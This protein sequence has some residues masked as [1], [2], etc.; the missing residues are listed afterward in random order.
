MSLNASLSIGAS[1]LWIN[2]KGIE[3]TGNN[4]ANV[5]TEGYSRQTLELSSTPALEFSG[6][7][8]GQGTT[9]SSISRETNSFV[10]KQLTGKI[11]D[12][13]EENGKSLPLE[14]IE[15][16][17]GIDDDSLSSSID[18]FFDAWQEL[19]TDSSASLQRQQVMQ[20]G[21]NL[22][23][24]FQSMVSDLNS[25]QEGINDDLSGTIATLN[26]QLQEI[27]DLN[28]RIVSAESTGVSANSLRDQRDLLLQGVSEVA[29][30]NYFE[31][32][33]GMV[34]VQLSSGLP[35]VTADTASLL[36]T[37]WNSGTL[38]L[39]LTSGASTKD[40]SGNDF[41]GEV[42][43]ILEVRDDYIP[44]LID[45]LDILAYNLATTVNS[46]HTGGVD[47][48]GNTGVDFYSFSSS[49]SDPWTGA[50]STLTMELTETSQVAAGT[51]AAPDNQLGDNENTLNMVALH[52]EALIDG[53][54]TFNDYYATI[55][56][57][58][59]LTVSQNTSALE[60][61]DDALTQMQNMRDSISG[62]SVDEEMIMLTQYQSG[63]EAA[64]R[65]LTAVDEML[66]TLM[67]I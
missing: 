36:A 23:L 49:G 58:V 35:L 24:E 51:I 26:Q 11:A 44:E 47:L 43:G 59:G 67:S 62:V 9:V 38:N 29:G 63:Y 41:G 31:E 33:N 16:I 19:S 32:S 56:S 17:V 34:S 66:E 28:V 55:A 53:T 46:V 10:S 52:S 22:A 27:A 40:L 64:A 5:N 1:G 12:Y 4:V 3:V 7:M 42:G 8:I 15:R 39:T 50:A 25:V 65:F 30:V 57:S 21:E 60:S 37:E 6:Q 20:L 13:G 48:D 2:Q 45:Q 54:S 18:E 14:E 61:A